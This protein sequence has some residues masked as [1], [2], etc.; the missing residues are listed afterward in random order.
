MVFEN[1]QTVFKKQSQRCRLNTVDQRQQSC[2]LSQHSLQCLKSMK[3][4]TNKAVGYQQRFSTA[5]TCSFFLS[6]KKNQCDTCCSYDKENLVHNDYVE[7]ISRKEEARLE[8]KMIRKAIANSNMNVTT[9][10][11]PCLSGHVRSRENFRIY[12]VSVYMKHYLC[13]HVLYVEY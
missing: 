1:L 7:H 11:K 8:K 5:K 9:T 13:A 10:V 4:I 3:Y 2:T 12:E 6:S